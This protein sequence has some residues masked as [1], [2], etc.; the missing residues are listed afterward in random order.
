MDRGGGV[1]IGLLVE[2]GVQAAGGHDFLAP[3]GGSTTTAAPPSLPRATVSPAASACQ[4]PASSATRASDMLP[5][6]HVLMSS[7]PSIHSRDAG[8]VHDLQ[9]IGLGVARLDLPRPSDSE[10][11]RT[12]S[13]VVQHKQRRKVERPSVVD[14][15]SSLKSVPA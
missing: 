1:K 6:I 15:A 2:H 11:R 14:A 4:R 9:Q 7:R 3:G 13:H 10:R 8:A 5:A 12:L